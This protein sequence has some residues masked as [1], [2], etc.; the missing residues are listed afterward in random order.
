MSGIRVTYAGLIAFVTGLV[1]IVFS[2][3]T[4]IIITRSLS[5][6]EFGTWRLIIT[7]LVYVVYIQPVITYWATREIARG[8][9]SG[10]TA[11]MSNALFSCIGIALYLVIIYFLGDQSDA[12][13]DILLSAF[14]MI[15]AL[16]LYNILTAINLGW[17]PQ[18]VSYGIIALEASKV[19]LLLI[20]V[21]WF[22]LGVS[23]II[24]AMTIAYIPSI[25]LLFIFG[26]EKIKSKIKIQYVKKW[27]RLSWLPLYPG[28]GTIVAALD[29]LLFT[30]ITGS[31]VGLAFYGA[32]IIIAK[33]C[34]Y[35]ILLSN[36]VYPKLLE[37]KEIGSIIQK[38]I[39]LIS[40]FA[41]P[42][43]TITIFYAKPAVY[44]L[45][46][47]Y[48][49]AYT[50]IIFM[51][52]RCFLFAYSVPFAR[53][54]EGIEKVDTDENASFKDYIK[55]KLFLVPSIRFIQYSG[56]VVSLT[57]V[58]MMVI[59]SSTDEEL[60]T[61]WAIVWLCSE[62]P[63]FIYFYIL[64]K[65]NFEFKLEIKM[66]VKYVLASIITIGT[67]YFISLEFLEFNPNIFEFLPNLLLFIGSGIFGYLALTYLIDERTRKIFGAIIYELKNRNM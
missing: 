41:I 43:A 19:P 66:L 35:A 8:I 61:Y 32:A 38:N 3:A 9:E 15:P 42:L 51:T 23:G 1:T 40:F 7:L 22:E 4:T 12:D 27:I 53:F 46:P 17:K 48:V 45:N 34:D 57:I 20:T 13:T 2:L 33:L 62:I 29:V 55:S 31:V 65:K 5:P 30:L 26:K 37:G 49:G 28:F 59:S 18:A 25:L 47:I 24:I 56:Y 36:A 60:V 63:F 21:I 10:K 16:F 67:S 52:I 39:T 11:L 64:M 50:A 14:I 6:E 44:A 58:L 54:L